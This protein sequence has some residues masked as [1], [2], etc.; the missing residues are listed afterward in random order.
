[1]RGKKKLQKKLTEFRIDNTIN[2]NT[3]GCTSFSNGYG[4]TGGKI[5]HHELMTDEI[6]DESEGNANMNVERMDKKVIGGAVRSL[7]AEF[8][9]GC[10]NNVVMQ[11][12][13][14][15]KQKNQIETIS[16]SKKAVCNYHSAHA[17]CRFLI[18][19][20]Y[21]LCFLV[22]TRKTGSY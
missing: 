1:M 6:R 5:F 2:Y 22:H 17:S 8:S 7:P 21:C 16:L 10:T 14:R 9:D 3:S 4:M 13:Y 20:L 12:A 15:L 18:L 11:T 19:N